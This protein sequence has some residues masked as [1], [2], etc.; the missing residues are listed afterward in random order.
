MLLKF[1]KI[2]LHVSLF[3]AVV[4][5]TSTFFPFIG[6]KDYFFRFSV[7][8]ALVFFILWWA[9]ESNGDEAWHRIREACRK[10]LFVAVSAF[11]LAVLLASLFA[12]DPHAAFWSN[13]ERGEGA[14]E[15]LHYYVFFSLL[16]V[17]FK[18]KEDWRLFFKTFLAVGT[19]MILYGVLADTGIATNFIS[20]YQ[21][22]VQ[23]GADWYKPLA[24]RFQGSLGNPAYVAPYLMFSL[25]YALY[26]WKTSKLSLQWLRTVTYGVPIFFLFLFFMVTQ[27]RGA[28]VGL[29]IAAYVF[30]VFFGFMKPRFRLLSLGILAVLLIFCGVLVY[31]RLNPSLQ[32]FPGGRMFDI[33]IGDK[34]LVAL[35]VFALAAGA[36]VEFARERKFLWWVLAGLVAVAFSSGTYAITSGKISL[37]DPTTSTRFWTWGSAWQ[38]I[39][40][41][42]VLG[43]GP[44]NFSTVFDKYFDPRHFIPG[45][46]TETWFDRAHSIYFDYLAETGV[47]GLATYIGIFVLLYMGFLGRKM[48]H[49]QNFSAT[50]KGLLVALPIGYLVQGVAI[51]DVLPVYIN[52][53]AFFAFGYYCLYSRGDSAQGISSH[54]VPL[55]QAAHKNNTAGQ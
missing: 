37:A 35:G 21:G 33:P 15:M 47:L 4:V 39:K 28:F 51:F 30:L 34:P 52:L 53:F 27:T 18:K 50:E 48:M 12:Y 25:F 3:S 7:E 31:F 8:L 41:R 44:E 54:D 6:G 36:I 23:G 13:Y 11:V 45:Q 16:V 49:A 43:W 40:E 9:F 22:A 2:L 5:M 55:R 24:N 38:G 17:L 1:S 26:L 19:L 14:F 20:Q 10:P 32:S 42:P 29:I 46:S